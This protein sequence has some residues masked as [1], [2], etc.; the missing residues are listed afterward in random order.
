MRY[1]IISFIFLSLFFSTKITAK[2]NLVKSL[3]EG[4]K[5][6]LIRHALAPGNG[7]PSNFDI[8]DCST[9]RNLNLEGIKQSKEI[10]KFFE[11][12]KI[13]IDLVLSSEWCRCIDTANN[14]FKN[15]KT[16]DALNSFY[17][18]KF[19]KNEKNQIIKLKKFI[20]E[21][22]GNNN[23]ILVTH[24]VVIN[25]ILGIGASSGEMIVIDKKYNLIGSI[26]F[27]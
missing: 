18:P 21:W 15:Y 13:K 4:K 9:Q 17:S 20:D 3:K 27:Y 14:A 5:I 16:F 1:Y 6:I 23:L 2:E 7:D 24:Y 11:T 19:Q 25:S 12:N 26:E 8:N 10:G 22:N